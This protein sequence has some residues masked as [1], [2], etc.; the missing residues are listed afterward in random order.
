MIE[1]MATFQLEISTKEKCNFF[2]I[3]INGPSLRNSGLGSLYETVHLLNSEVGMEANP[4]QLEYRVAK[5]WA[6]VLK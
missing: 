1:R 2:P 3:Q 5:Q 4:G 6:F